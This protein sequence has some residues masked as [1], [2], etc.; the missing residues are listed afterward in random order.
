MPANIL[1]DLPKADNTVTSS[2]AP[3]HQPAVLKPR[4]GSTISFSK[5]SRWRRQCY[6]I[7]AR[8]LT[9]CRNFN[10]PSH[11][12]FLASAWR[13]RPILRR[14]NHDPVIVLELRHNERSF[15]V[16]QE[17][18]AAVATV[19][20]RPLQHH[21]VTNLEGHNLRSPI[22]V[23]PSNCGLL[24]FVKVGKEAVLHLLPS[25]Y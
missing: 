2:T 4:I 18:L 13:H 10:K 22:Q 16:L 19:H 24:G 12:N 20:R 8:K 6:T 17:H 25:V 3:S 15:Q 21:K 5:N 9:R 1:P 11:R 23:A 14:P 7:V